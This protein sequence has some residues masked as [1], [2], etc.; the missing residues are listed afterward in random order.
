[1]AKPARKTKKEKQARKT[2]KEKPASLTKHCNV[3][4]KTYNALP[5]FLFIVFLALLFF[6][7]FSC[8]VF[9]GRSFI[10]M[11]QFACFSFLVFLACFSF[12]VFQCWLCHCTEDML[13]FISVFFLLDFSFFVFLAPQLCKLS[14]MIDCLLFF[15]NFSCLLFIFCFSCWLCHC[16]VSLLALLFLQDLQLNFSFA[17]LFF[18]Q[19]ALPLQKLEVACRG[20]SMRL[21]L[22]FIS[23]FSCL[24]FFF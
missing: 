21:Q 10:A 2:R 24:L 20:F 9:L 12:F 22:L 11:H 16:Y 1:M 5:A 23:C 15:Y 17:Q 7:C 13:A 6:F 4:N 8:L 18:L 14:A 3:T 19:W